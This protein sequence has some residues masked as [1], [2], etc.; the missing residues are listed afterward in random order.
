MTCLPP[1]GAPDALYA[2]DLPGLVHRHFHGRPPVVNAGGERV[3]AVRGV[4]SDLRRIIREQR[5]AY[6]TV[7]VECPVVAAGEPEGWREAMFSG[8]KATRRAKGRDA[9]I[10]PQ[11]ALIREIV[12][13]MRIPVLEAPGFEAD[14]GLAVAAARAEQAG[15]VCVVVT[16]DKDLGQLV[17][18]RC[19]LWNLRPSEKAPAVVGVDEV[20]AR[21]GVGPE[22]LGDLLALAGDNGDDVPGVPGVGPAKAAALLQTYGSLSGVLRNAASIRGKL[23]ESIRAHASD[24]V[25]SRLLVSL[26]ADAPVRWDLARMRVGGFDVPRVVKLL[27]RVGVDS[28]A[29][30]ATR[31]A[32]VPAEV[33]ERDAGW[34]P[35]RA[36]AAWR[37]ME[38][39]LT[40]VL[41]RA[42]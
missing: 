26:R 7:A 34:D 23:G 3:E 40:G 16:G 28:S 13:A 15:L 37:A 5:P 2:V 11:E 42:A 24:A 20:R 31:K 33:L 35:M 27:D 39:E 18:P 21:W 10:A 25:M 1:P 19:L 38:A 9:A 32:P 6:L 36:L 22:L 8:Y 4:I 30:K 41:R 14:D 29:V 12:D 17:G